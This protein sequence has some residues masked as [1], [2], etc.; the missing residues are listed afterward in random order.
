MINC[1]RKGNISRA[2]SREPKKWTAIVR[3]HPPL[4]APAR[5][6]GFQRRSQDTLDHQILE[7]EGKAEFE[8]SEADRKAIKS[9][10]IPSHCCM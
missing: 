9:Y 8:A 1:L 7:D 5:I 2:N 10:A 3:F 6:D 4:K